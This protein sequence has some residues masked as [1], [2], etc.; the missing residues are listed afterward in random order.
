MEVEVDGWGS[1]PFYI[2][3]IKN[4]ISYPSLSGGILLSI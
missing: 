4:M 3:P 2:E 1:L